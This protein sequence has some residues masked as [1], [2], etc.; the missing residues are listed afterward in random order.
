MY[1]L[2]S[3]FFSDMRGPASKANSSLRSINLAISSRGICAIRAIDPDA[4]NRF[5]ENVIPMKG[6]MIHLEN[7]KQS[8]Q[9]YDRD[10]Q[11]WSQI[12]LHKNLTDQKI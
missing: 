6:R 10:G 12:G 5:L 11:V 1:S 4:A 9:L 3:R 7:G 2:C 8:S